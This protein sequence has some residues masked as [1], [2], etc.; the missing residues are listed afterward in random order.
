MSQVAI[1]QLE[2]SPAPPQPSRELL[3]AWLL[4]LLDR[5]ASHG[6][7]LRR[8]LELHGVPTESGAMY[9]TLRKLDEDGLTASAWAKSAAGPR[10][11]HYKLTTKGRSE[12]AELAASIAVKRNIHNAFL[13]VHEG[14]SGRANLA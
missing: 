10:R 2:H 9:R 6:Y 3:T 4:L 14:E 8:Q 1:Q 7:E 13:M 5:E 12:L 11:R